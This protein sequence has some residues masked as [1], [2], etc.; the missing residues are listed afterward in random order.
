MAGSVNRCQLLGHV[1]KDPEIRAMQNGDRVANFSMATSESWKDKT[2]GERKELTEWSRVVLWGPLVDVVEKYVHKGS[3]IYIE[4]KL[5][6]RKWTDN[7]GVE[8]YTTEVVV[9]RFRGQLVLLD[10][11]PADGGGDAAPAP[12]AGGAAPID[13]D[14]PF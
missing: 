8:K 3:K 6:T 5:Q 14:I 2:T 7:A 12:A 11:K 13:D 9:D 1:G 10:K 4:G